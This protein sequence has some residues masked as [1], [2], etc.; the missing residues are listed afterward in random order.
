MEIMTVQR[1]LVAKKKATVMRIFVTP[2]SKLELDQGSL[3]ISKKHAN[4]PKIGKLEEWVVNILTV[5]LI[6]TFIF[7]G[8]GGGH[9]VPVLFNYCRETVYIYH[10]LFSRT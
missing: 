7:M 6:S 9:N 5:L 1:H 2:I 10:F 8:M 4:L 3:L